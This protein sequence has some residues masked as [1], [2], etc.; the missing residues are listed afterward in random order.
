MHVLKMDTGFK[1]LLNNFH[2]FEIPS[3]YLTGV[4]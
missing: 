2:L 1:S 3:L 4:A